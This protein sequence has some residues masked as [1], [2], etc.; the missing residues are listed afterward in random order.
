MATK[1]FTRT[2]TLPTGQRKYFRGKTQEIAD[3]K[4]EEAKRQL[5]AGIDLSQN[6]TVAQL[7]Q[8]WFDTVK[9][10]HLSANSIYTD[11]TNINNY[12][13]Q[14]FLAG[15]NI[16][17]VRPAHIMTAMNNIA[18]LS[19]TIQ[20]K[21]LQAYRG[22]FSFAVDNRLIE[23][24]PVPETLKARG[25]TPEE[26]APLTPEQSARLM[27]AT[28]DLRVHT[29]VALMLGAGLR[30]EEACGLMWEDVDLVNGIIHV[31]HAL[32]FVRGQKPKVTSD[33]KSKAAKRDIPIPSWLRALLREEKSKTNSVYVLHLLNGKCMTLSAFT[34]MW[35][36]IKRRTADT[37]EELGL[38][39]DATHPDV[40][41][42]LDFHVHPHLL[43]HTC[44]TRW[45]EAG[46]DIKEVQYL[47]GH[48]TPEMTLRVY[49]HYDHEAR[50][51]ETLAKIQQA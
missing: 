8:V 48:S 36:A 6:L 3:A 11:I 49:A 31:R 12:V 38:P 22:I 16:L 29:A 23:R 24:T 25:S 35:E 44:I 51:A 21:V 7:T 10:P 17:D 50:F 40:I 18:H 47:A 5:N 1:Y 39:I 28:K 41:R 46:L 26:K 9:R 15:M 42:T 34:S 33:L 37:P 19:K 20:S 45:V 32:P 43:R 4:Y 13:L 2:L 27:E 14:P 30:R